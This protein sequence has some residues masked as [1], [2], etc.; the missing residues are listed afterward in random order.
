LLPRYKFISY[1]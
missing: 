1:Y